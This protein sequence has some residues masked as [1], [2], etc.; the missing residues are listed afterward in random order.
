MAE[1]AWD[2]ASVGAQLPRRRRASRLGIVAAGVAV[3]GVIGVGV[4]LAV[5]HSGTQ[6]SAATTEPN[7]I[8][9]NRY[10]VS[11]DASWSCLRGAAAALRQPVIGPRT[12]TQLSGTTLAAISSLHSDQMALGYKYLA[13]DHKTSVSVHARAGHDSA[14][15]RLLPGALANPKNAVTIA[16]LTGYL[17]EQGNQSKAFATLG[18][19][20]YVVTIDSPSAALAHQVLDQ[21]RQ[22]SAS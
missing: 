4:G 22:V 15:V 21:L 19:V 8:K 11:C 6:H 14:I 9:F 10:Q 5:Q 7:V 2:S 3:L 17:V 20:H 16:G 12:A 1:I 18:S 13:P